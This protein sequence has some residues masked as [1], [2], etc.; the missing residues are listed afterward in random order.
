MNWEAVGAIS[1]LI[2]ALGVIASLGY[3]AY[4]IR[5]NTKQLEQNERASIAA[6]VNASLTNYRENRRYIYTSSEVSDI[7]LKGMADPA[8]LAETERYRFRLLIQNLMDALWDMYSQTVLTGFSSETWATQGQKVVERVFTTA[9]G[10]WF[11][12][13]YR[14]DYS[15]KFRAEIDRILQA[16]PD[17]SKN[18]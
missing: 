2:G 9:G 15:I 14:D 1:E 10:R 8:A 7:C 5:Q 18:H 17:G 13:H 4:Q 12:T 3:V 16:K 11:W 6:A